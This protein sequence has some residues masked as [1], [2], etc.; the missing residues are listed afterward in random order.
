MLR[1]I[2]MRGDGKWWS[3]DGKKK[4]TTVTEEYQYGWRC[5]YSWWMKMSLLIMNGKGVFI[6]Y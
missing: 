2:D 1:D 3:K 5:H 6:E 4:L